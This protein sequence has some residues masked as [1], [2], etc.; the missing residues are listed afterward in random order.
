MCL[1][2]GG[3]SA[4]NHWYAATSTADG[5]HG[6][7]AGCQGAHRAARGVRD[8]QR[9]R[10]RRRAR[11]GRLVNWPAALLGALR[12]S[13]VTC[14]S[15]P[16]GSSAAHP[17]HRDRRRRRRGPPLVGW[18]AVT[19]RA[20]LAARRLFLSSS[21]GRRRT[22]GRSRSWSRRT[23]R[24][25]ACRCCRTSPA[26]RRPRARS[27]STRSPARSLLLPVVHGRARCDLRG[28]RPCSAG[29][30]SGSRVDL[31][32]APDIPTRPRALSA[33][34]CSTWPRCSRRW[35]STAPSS[36]SR[37]RGE[38]RRRRPARPRPLRRARALGRLRAAAAGRAGLLARRAG[39]ARVLER[40]PLRRR[41]R[42]AQG[43]GD[44]LVRVGGVAQIEDMRRTSSRRGATSWRPTPRSTPSGAGS[45]LATSRRGRSRVRAV[46]A[47][48]HGR[49][50]D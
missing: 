30:S 37:R 43:H 31:V 44:V 39:R 40:H 14:S 24:R 23:T 45:S 32:H 6:Q 3:S 2:S 16:S 1:C 26:A 20:D 42:R 38:P 12:A 36:A 29:A 18:A 21:C 50:L 47:R 19:G 25:Q 49:L 46:P 4:L 8:R 22:S 13:S 27:R 10:H 15:T 9:A 5:P 11:A 33:S 41:G 17:E 34:R 7:P 28:A 48:A 35:P